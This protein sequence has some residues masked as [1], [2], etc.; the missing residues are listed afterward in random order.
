MTNDYARLAAAVIRY[1]RRFPEHTH[2]RIKEQ[3][4]PSGP[5][6]TAIERGEPV[7]G[8]TLRRLERGLGWP[9]GF[10]SKILADEATI[11]ELLYDYPP[12]AGPAETRFTGAGD[13]FRDTTGRALADIP[14]ITLAF[15]QYEIGEELEER[16]EAQNRLF[17]R[18][19]SPEAQAV[20]REYQ[21]EA[22]EG[23]VVVPVRAI[24][25]NDKTLASLFVGNATIATGSPLG[26]ITLMDVPE[27]QAKR[28]N[29]ASMASPPPELYLLDEAAREDTGQPNPGDVS[30]DT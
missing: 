8:F 26:P 4:G 22:P 23:M 29:R 5:T 27:E 30:D 7:K 10:A 24:A 3:G 13:V 25:G 14:T 9:E 21:R 16:R 20:I 15:L 12:P 1:R 17:A 19:A 11:E 2:E 28:M 6:V 18:L